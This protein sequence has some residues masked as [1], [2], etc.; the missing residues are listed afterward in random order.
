MIVK[1]FTG[2]IFANYYTNFYSLI[3]ID[4]E[5]F[6]LENINIE[7][8]KINKTKTTSNKWKNSNWIYYQKKWK[9]QSSTLK[10]SI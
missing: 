1:A 6:G 7:V 10:F 8:S 3:E 5:K 4:K 2:E 9:E